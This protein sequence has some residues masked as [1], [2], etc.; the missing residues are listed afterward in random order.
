MMPWSLVAVMLVGA[1]V[2]I[3][4]TA[5]QVFRTTHYVDVNHPLAKDSWSRGSI[6]APWRSLDHAFQQL[7]PGDTLLVRGGTFT[8]DSITLMQKNSG[9]DGAPI[10]IKAYPGESV[11][12]RN[13]GPIN[14]FGANWWTLDGLVFVEA[15]SRSF[16]LGLHVGLG[17]EWNVVAEHIII[18][19]C[20]FKNGTQSVISIR[21]A[22]DLLIENNNFHHVRPGVPFY[23]NSG[24]PTGWEASAIAVKYRGD[25]IVIK[26]NRFE[27]IGS[28]GVHIGAQSNL[29]GASIKSIS[30]VDNDF[31]INRPHE[32]IFGNVGENAIDIKKVRGPILVSGNS[33][34]GFRPTTPQQDAH[35]GNGAGIVIHNDAQNV[36]VERNLFDDNTA[37]IVIAKGSLGRPGGTRDVTVRNNIMRGARISGNK[38]GFALRVSQSDN[39]RVYHNTFY[40][41]DVALI[42]NDSRGTFKNN[43][44][45]GGEVR[46]NEGALWEANHNAWSHISAKVPYAFWGNDDLWISDPRLGADLYP[47]ADSPVIDSGQDLGLSDDYCRRLRADGYPD[48]GAQEYLGDPQ[49]LRTCENRYRVQVPSVPNVGR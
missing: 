22:H 21:S 46:A 30:I 18:R 28:D 38:G 1:L 48:V 14:L 17:D 33:I 47:L 49:M 5:C 12:I 41:N 40:D 24:A 7:Q 29:P 8:F 11:V 26:G 39:V 44:V 16:R 4:A 45:F 27:E 25:N 9:R 20:E 37:H 42:G 31:W 2:V 23:D 13:S 10:T 35:G 3:L 6:D 34:R 19:N 36:T 43:I 32:S 15:L